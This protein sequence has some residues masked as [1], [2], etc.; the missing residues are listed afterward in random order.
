[1]VKAPAAQNLPKRTRMVK[2]VPCKEKGNS[3]L[4]YLYVE[5]S[6]IYFLFLETFSRIPAAMQQAPGKRREATCRIQLSCCLLLQ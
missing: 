2:A 1:M 5:R 6:T 4:E 3:L